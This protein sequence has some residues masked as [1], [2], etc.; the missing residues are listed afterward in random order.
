MFIILTI[1]MRYLFNK[2]FKKIKA[3]SIILGMLGCWP[4]SQGRQSWLMGLT[5]RL[6]STSTWP[7]K[8]IKSLL[9]YEREHVHN[10]WLHTTSVDEITTWE[11]K[12]SDVRID[13]QLH[14]YCVAVLPPQ[15]SLLTPFINAHAPNIHKFLRHEFFLL[16]PS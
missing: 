3:V 7:K 1:F 5:G 2:N 15:S 6:W 10:R 14:N 12:I 16:L 13:V 9:L 11:R 8:Q 4:I